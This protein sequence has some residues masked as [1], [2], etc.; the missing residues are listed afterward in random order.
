MRFLCHV[1]AIS[2]A[3]SALLM[4]SCGGSPPATEACSETGACGLGCASDVDCA[5]PA[6]K[7][8][9]EGRCNQGTCELR[10]QAGPIASQLYGDCHRLEC[11]EQGNV[12]K[13][14]DD[15]EVY[16]DGLECTF[17]ICD[18]GEPLNLPYPDGFNCPES[19]SKHCYKT[20]CIEC[21]TFISGA[22]TECF[23][24]PGYHCSLYWC[25]PNEC[26][27]APCGG[28][29]R[30]CENTLPCDGDSACLSGRCENGKCVEAACDDGRS[31]DEETGMDCGGPKCSACPAGQGCIWP[32]DCES[33]VCMKGECQAP[34]CFDAKKNGSETGTDC[35]GPCEPC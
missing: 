27:K 32:S 26:V 4:P 30:P 19:P 24:M 25:V 8:C 6:D 7:R 18:A 31:N 13:M 14:R 9:G 22:E 17:D 29:C 20:Q 3:G 21:V 11:D 33:D 2:V 5:Q 35:G 28:E 23:A 12:V 10:I 34:S 16:D 15:T 1:I